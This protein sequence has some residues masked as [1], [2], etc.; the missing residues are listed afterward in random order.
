MEIESASHLNAA[1]AG[2]ANLIELSDVNYGIGQAE[3]LKQINFTS[4]HRRIGVV[5]RNGSGKSTLAR[6]LCGLVQPDSGSLRICGI[7]VANDRRNAIRTVGM[8]FQN[9]DHQIIFPTVE[10]ELVFGLKQMGHSNCDASGAAMDAL[11]KFNCVGWADRSVSTLSQG[12]RHL[13]CLIAVLLM[14]PRL[15]VLDEPYAGLDIPTTIQLKKHLHAIEAS[16]VHISHQPDMLRDY[17]QIVWVDNGE[18]VNI[19]T[20]ENTLKMFET[21][22]EELGQIDALV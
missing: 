11:E 8:L 6:L 10:E 2:T 15:V 7:D 16:I 22:M 18:I 14:K 4:S 20:P 19:G 1:D 12:Q 9:P 3:I 13:V 17:D 5:G 21:R